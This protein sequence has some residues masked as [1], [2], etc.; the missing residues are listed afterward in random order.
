MERLPSSLSLE[1]H[2]TQTSFVWHII[3]IGNVK[4]TYVVGGQLVFLLCLSCDWRVSLYGGRGLHLEL[5]AGLIGWLR[6]GRGH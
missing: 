3:C 6:R 2:M 1:I 5:G 4:L